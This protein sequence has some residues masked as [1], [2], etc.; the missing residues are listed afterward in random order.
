MTVARLVVGV[1]LAL[2]LVVAPRRAVAA[3]ALPIQ[4]TRGD[5]VVRAEAG[6]ERMARRV[7]DRAARSLVKISADLPDLPRPAT[8]EIRVVASSDD[9]AAAAPEGRGAPRWAAGVAYPDLGVIVVAVAGRGTA[10]DVDKTVDHELAHLAL[11]AAVPDAPRWLH[12]GF[13]WQHAEDLGFDR[14]ETLIGMA[15]TGSVIPLDELTWGFP[16]AEA[17]ASRAYAESYDF[18]G[19]LAN[20]GRWA[21]ADDDGDR[22]PFQNFLRG[23]GEGKSLDQAAQAAFGA[24]MDELFAE[25][26]ADLSRRYLLVPAALF[27][28]G[29]WILAAVLLILGYWRRRRRAKATLARWAATEAAADLARVRPPPASAPWADLDLLT[30][31]ADEPSE[32]PDTDPGAPL[33]PWVN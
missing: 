16:A 17:P 25:W 5:V 28:T 20:R 21:D 32:E 24:S 30:D 23:L 31:A 19:Y 3:P 11:G 26:K 12:E 2:A 14:I 6:L 9:L 29:I 4:L 13:A 1:W 22:Y 7:A 10:F 33:P 27:A 8:V 18:V 15:W